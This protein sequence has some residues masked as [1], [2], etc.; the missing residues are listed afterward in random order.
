MEE[1]CEEGGVVSVMMEEGGVTE[2]DF[3][4]EVGECVALRGSSSPLSHY[5]DKEGSH[6]VC[7]CLTL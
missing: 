4:P 1:V 5:R 3:V 2:K 7:M 6:S